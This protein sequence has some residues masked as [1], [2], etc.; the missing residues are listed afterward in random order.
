LDV[1][2]DGKFNVADVAALQKWLLAVPDATL[3]DRKARDFCADNR[4]DAF[5]PALM[6]RSLIQDSITVH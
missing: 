1:N 5:D 6:K 4:L 3:A 2:S